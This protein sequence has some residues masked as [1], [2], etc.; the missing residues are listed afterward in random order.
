MG[1][2]PEKQQKLKKT[3]QIAK[4]RM[5]QWK[6]SY[7]V[8]YFEFWTFYV[9][10]CNFVLNFHE[11]I[12]FKFKF[13]N[14][15]LKFFHLNKVDLSSFLDEKVWILSHSKNNH[16]K[17]NGCTKRINDNYNFFKFASC[18]FR[19]TS[20][21]FLKL[22]CIL[23]GFV[24]VKSFF[25]KTFSSF[26]FFGI[27]EKHAVNQI[28]DKNQFKFLIAGTHRRTFTPRPS[29]SRPISSC[30]APVTATAAPTAAPAPRTPPRP[31]TAACSTRPP[32]TPPRPLR[33]PTAVKPPVN[34]SNNPTTTFPRPRP[35]PL[36][37]PPHPSC[38]PNS[39]P[40]TAAGPAGTPASATPPGASTISRRTPRPPVF[41]SSSNS[42][43]MA[44]IPC[45]T[46]IIMAMRPARWV[47]RW[48]LR[49]PRR[50][51]AVCTTGDRSWLRTGTITIIIISRRWVSGEKS[52][53]KAAILRF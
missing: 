16:N 33:R 49:V 12:S 1:L 50:R 38:R 35:W 43:K 44:A 27:S 10:I 20:G 8:F 29:S 47:P 37:P 14:F 34:N 26:Q 22:F 21:I 7:S 9:I 15:T 30:Q 25:L 6:F 19:L 24:S 18:V 45:S 31:P 51:I 52:D 40:R 3:V 13:F 11:H 42:T 39:R 4:F 32:A 2:A 17:S 48:V 5:R 36:P 23:Y 28:N 46:T 53:I 41:C